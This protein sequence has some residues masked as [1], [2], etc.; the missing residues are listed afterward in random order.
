MKRRKIISILLIL[1]IVFSNFQNIALAKMIGG[2][3]NL[4]SLGAC[5]R[6]IEFKFS[7]GWSVVKGDYIAYVEDGKQYAAYC[8][9]P[10][11]DGVDELGDYTVDIT[12]V[13]EDEKLYRVI[14]NGFPY[15]TAQ[16]LGVENDYDAYMATKQA[17]KCILVDRDVR[18]NYRGKDEAG[19]KVVDLMERLVDIGKN[20]TQK[21]QEA[22]LNISKNG[23]LKEEGNYYTQLFSVSSSVDISNYDIVATANMPAGAFIANINNQEKTSF[24]GNENFKLVIPKSSMTSDFDVA[25]N[26]MG[27]CR[28]Y[29]VLYGKTRI[30]NSQDYAVATDPYGDYSNVVTAS[31]KL[32]TGSIKIIKTDAETGK[33]IDGVTFQLSNS[34]GEVIGTAKTNASG[35]ATFSNLYQGTYKLKEIATN[36]NYILN[37]NTFDVFVEYNKTTTQ[38]ITNDHKKGSIKINKIDS[39]TSQAI[40]G[41]TF[42]LQKEDGTIVGTS[43]TNNKGE[44]Y[45]NNIR[46][47]KYKLKEVSTNS[48]YVLDSSTFDV[49]VEHNKTTTQNITNNHKKGNIKINKTDSETSQ[50]IEGVTFQLQKEDGAIVGTSTTNN[51]GE[52]YFNNIRIGKYKLKEVSTN[53]NYIL[54]SSTFD[55]VVEHNKTTTKNITNEHKRGNLVIRKVDKDN[56]NITLGNVE[57]KLFSEEFQKVIGTYNT[58][59]NGEIVINNIRTGNYKLIETNSG[60]WYNLSADVDVIVN[61]NETTNSVIENEL[62]KG[63][64]KI[65]KID[66]ED[67]KVR[68][69]NTKFEILD[70]NNNVLE[71]VVT[72]SNGEAITKEYP[73]RD[74]KNIKI[75]EVESNEWYVLN[76]EVEVVE[77]KENDRGNI[78]FEN[79]KKKGQIRIIKVDLEDNEIRIPNV[80]FN[81]LDETGK[82]VDTLI[83]DE[84][85]EA[86]SKELP[87]DQVY[88]LKEIKTNEDYILNEE[89]KE[90]TLTYNQVTD[91]VWE[92]ERKKGQ[93]EVYKVDS[94]NNETKLEG[95]EFQIINYKDEVV[96]T[97]TTNSE[98]YAITSKISIGEYKIKEI[99]LGTNEEYILNDEVQTIKVEADKIKSIQIE[100][101]HKK[102]N[103][104]I[105]KVDLDNNTIPVSDVEFEVTD[106]DGYKYKAISDENG[107]AYIENIR[108]GI[109]SIKEIATNKIYKI[110]EETYEAEIK[111]NEPAETT[112]TNEKLKGQIEIYK[113]D[114]EDNK[115]KLEGVEFKVINSNNE[116]IETITTNSDGYA[117]TSRIPI[118]EY[119]LKE[120]KTDEMHI[121]NNEI[122][123]V[124]VSTDTISKLE[125]TNE[126]I[127]GKI[128]IVK[129]SQDDNFINGKEAGSP[130]GDVQFKVYDINNNIVDEIITSADGIAITKPLDKGFYTIKEEISGEWYL[131]NNNIFDAEIK[132]HEEVVE[133]SITNESEKPSVDIEKIGLIQTSASQE[134]KYDFK[135]RNTGNVPLSNFVWLDYLPT[136]HVRISKLITGTYNQELTY[137][138]Y[139]KTN[140]NDFK[141]L[142]DN[143]NTLVNNYIDFSNLEME[144]DEYVTE[145]KVYYGTVDVGFESVINPYIFVRVKSDVQNDDIFTNKTRIEGY[146]KTYFLWDEDE[147]TTKLYE[148]EVEVKK[149]PRT[150]Y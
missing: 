104:K 139:Y 49:L 84:N 143:L 24:A 67:N 101:E 14:V 113:V 146:N 65:I 41:V 90:I 52:A 98:G 68:I 75:H 57:F 22:D 31:Y 39:E 4:T 64:V 120:I 130:I 93:I 56:N 135:I 48:N 44:A 138:I 122:F 42:Q 12:K 34:S 144:T 88:T 106:K 32:N 141:L 5:R 45:F 99:S 86:T 70:E 132:E 127:K 147:H 50:A 100:N 30:A 102:G 116:I 97:I 40:E 124:N 118:G 25:I 47:G 55:V 133:I 8:I 123:K 43:T 7:V 16:E 74:Y 17:I 18:S 36:G 19:K 81:V 78:T 11:I 129:T 77:L 46:I 33:T 95:V 54:N 85:G 62:K 13:L 92:N 142:K 2:A 23:N 61:W 69:S 37:T 87:I 53:S 66:S 20:G 114:A 28:T 82:V 63:S 15:K 51:K 140:K 83:T 150:G 125:I 80:E 107:I 149:L 35:V 91:I 105:Y 108:I 76:D 131:L 29:P 38:N 21:Y 26:I 3:K 10:G 72:D 96:E 60:K 121:L 110:S 126:R 119:K 6:N 115:V 94:Q 1:I 9:M 58:D 112:I 117:I 27:K 89:I 136:D 79:T 59:V 137:S 128:K 148:K 109:V 111:W 134:I 145:F 103:L 71:E 73:I